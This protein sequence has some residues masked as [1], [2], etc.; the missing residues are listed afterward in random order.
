VTAPEPRGG[1]PDVR[2]A[3]GATVVPEAGTTAQNLPED[4]F[5]RPGEWGCQ[6]RVMAE[7]QDQESRVV[8]FFGD[9]SAPV[10]V[11]VRADFLRRKAQ[12]VG[13]R[14]ARRVRFAFTTEFAA[15]A[16][17]GTATLTVQRVTGCL[18]K[19]KYKGPKISTTR[20]R[21]GAT[22]ATLKVKRPGK[23]YY[24][25]KL[26]FGGTKLIRPGQDPNLLYLSAN[27]GKFGFAPSRRF[28]YC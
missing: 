10:P 21:F 15:E 25:G 13:S 24:V 3:L 19:K 7:G 20:A 22:G 17:G 27:R 28:P 14:S 1:L 12:V 9:W 11:L 18:G 8:N 23:G 26:S 2:C 5:P 4:V 6:A 16:A